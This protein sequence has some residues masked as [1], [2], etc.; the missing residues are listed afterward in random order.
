M[1][2]RFV[3]Y[4]NNNLPDELP[5]EC[6]HFNGMEF[7]EGKSAIAA[8][9]RFAEAL[10]A[11]RLQWGAQIGEPDISQHAFAVH[12]GISGDRPEERYRLYE[13]A[14]R[15]PPIWLLAKIRE[16]TGFSLDDLIAS[17][18]LGRP[19]PRAGSSTVSPQA[20]KRGR[21]PQ[22]PRMGGSEPKAE[23]GDCNNVVP[24]PSRTVTAA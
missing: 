17:L 20:R 12:L 24:I 23:A 19:I 5:T 8:R 14:K 1:I 15:E 4:V 22:R 2:Q 21:Q 16:V 7:D 9:E 11:V 13:R 10:R 3:G 6:W 18:P